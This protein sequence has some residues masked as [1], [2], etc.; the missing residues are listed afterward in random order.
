MFDVRPVDG[1][2]NLD[3]GKINKVERSTILKNKNVR[4]VEPAHHGRV[5]DIKL[6]D[7][8]DLEV[9]RFQKYLG[10][11]RERNKFERILE[12]ENLPISYDSSD[13]Y[14][15]NYF[16]NK[17]E[18]EAPLPAIPE[19]YPE[20]ELR[21]DPLE[22]SFI[23][24]E[25]IVK[26]TVRKKDGFSLAKVFSFYAPES[27]RSKR[28]SFAFSGLGLVLFLVIFGI[29]FFHKAINLKS[30]A[31]NDG[32]LAYVN[33]AQAKEEIMAKDFSG[34]SL[35]FNDAYDQFDSLSKEFNSFGGLTAQVARFIPYL[36]K[37]SSGKYLVDAGKDIS[38]SGVLA[39][40]LF[41]VL[42]GVKN[43][44]GQ[45]QSVSFL[46]IFQKSHE[47]LQEISGLLDNAD[48]N[49]AKVNIDDIPTDQKDKVVAFK[50]DLPKIKET[51]NG[52]LDNSQVFTD[53]LG[54][55]GPRKYLFLFQ[56][57][58]EMRAT[59][60]FIGTY[61]IMDIF[62]GRIKK[63]FV[64]GIFNPDGQ[65]K[66][67][68]VPPAPIQ[69]ISAAWS[70]HDSN[71]FPD[72]PKSAEKAAWFYGKT[73]GPTVDGVIAM[74]PTVMQKLLEITGPIEMPEYGVTV[75]KDNFIEKIQY[76]VEDNYD[77]S[78][79]QPKKIL[80][81]LAPE[82][83]DRIFNLK[84]FSKISQVVNVLAQSLNEKHILIYSR[85]YDIEQK[86]SQSGWSGEI[87]NNSKD[88]LSVINTNINGYKT[89]GVIDEKIE[90]SAE[91][92]SDGS[93]VD[94]LMITR[95]HNGGNKEFDWWNKVNADYMRVYVPKGSTLISAEGQTREFNSPP[96]DYNALGF[97]KDPQVQMEEESMKIDENSG[98]RI[99]E[100]SGKTVFANWV[101]VSPQETV[102]VKYKYLLPFKIMEGKN[103]DS[104]SMLVQKQSGSQ[105]SGFSE[106]ITFP[107][108]M[109]SAWDYPGDME[110]KQEGD[111]NFISQNTDLKMDRFFGVAFSK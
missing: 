12:R 50:N 54:G 14:S 63:F 95:H 109:K 69:K 31:L 99:Y 101:Y 77:K 6:P 3:Y 87:L 49:L 2:G 10:E 73:G 61:G 88:Y 25:E 104:Y 32:K 66:E 46:D 72:F 37:F 33:L 4:K 81:D 39:G 84:D 98:T 38:K 52:F 17:K 75:D 21:E 29:S 65:L 108:S 19:F 1:E 16:E 107:K 8:K 64:D 70:L 76:E 44:I 15:L 13:D 5:Y 103:S 24:E 71:W 43:P 9:Q 94:T 7:P 111:M 40:E 78:L 35:K 80:A 27:F 82:L 85:N 93:V 18:E 45:E 42:D 83:L 91:I 74:T 58:Q 106:K 110:H 47:K 96:L 86:L 60:G 90:H 28:L 53:F 97:K 57:N 92:Q 51:I 26:K 23:E 89:D 59:G 55:N 41:Q 102:V 20:E 67:K 30:L 79:N 105:G 22:E 56:N 68:V 62:N 100:D 36:S 34:S 11:E 48:K